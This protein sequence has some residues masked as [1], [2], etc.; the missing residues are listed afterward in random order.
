MTIYE[1]VK[2]VFEKPN[3][4]DVLVEDIV[5]SCTGYPSFWYGKSAI[6]CFTKQLRHAKRSLDRGFTFNEIFEGR[7]VVNTGSPVKTGG[8]AAVGDGG[9]VMQTPGS[10][11]VGSGESA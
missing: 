2:I 1:Y 6:R 8:Y 10:E 5:W 4:S 7:D 11:D 9:P 3:M